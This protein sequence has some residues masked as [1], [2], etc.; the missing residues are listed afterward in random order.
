[1]DLIE[2]PLPQN[3]SDVS[4]T[5]LTNEDETDTLIVLCLCSRTLVLK[6]G[7]DEGAFYTSNLARTAVWEDCI[8]QIHPKGI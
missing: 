6:I 3:A 4:T 2:S 7:D 5:K 1:L 8:M